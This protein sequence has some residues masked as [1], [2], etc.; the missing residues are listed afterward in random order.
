MR[1]APVRSEPRKSPGVGRRRENG[2]AMVEFV[3]GLIALLAVAV[4]I[5]AVA[6]LSRADTESFSAAQEEAVRRSM[7]HGTTD[8]FSPVADVSAGPDGL[9]L[10]KDDETER[11]SLSRIRSIA[12][13]AK[14]SASPWPLR[15]DGAAPDH[16]AIATVARGGE[17]DALFSMRAGRGEADAE[18]PPA[19]KPLFGLEPAATLHNEVWLPQTG[20]VP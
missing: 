18:L 6:A 15:P 4:G 13:H 19:A 8:P 14:P 5:L 10:T 16:D 7:G 12:G 2:Q 1:H 17:G 11:G 20:G 9:P 3:V